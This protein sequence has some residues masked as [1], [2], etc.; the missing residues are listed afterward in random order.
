MLI[1]NPAMK[2]RQRVNNYDPSTYKEVDWDKME[3]RQ[4]AVLLKKHLEG[5][6]GKDPWDCKDIKRLEGETS[7]SEKQKFVKDICMKFHADKF[8]I[9]QSRYFRKKGQTGFTPSG[10]PTMSY[11]ESWTKAEVFSNDVKLERYEH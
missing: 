3:V 8:I 11:F 7:V 10:D 1:I 2:K 9:L 4:K 5:M 6:W